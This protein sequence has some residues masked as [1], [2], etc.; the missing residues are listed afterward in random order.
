MSFLQQ[1]TPVVLTWN[2]APN[3]ARTLGRLAWAREVIVVDSGSE[4]A[5]AALVAAAPNARLIAHPF[6]G[7]AEQWRFALEESGIA[8]PWVL[9]LDADYL[10]DEALIAELAALSPPPEV[11]AY[12]VAFDY[13]IGG[14]RLRGS[15]Y[16]PNTVLFRRGAATPW[17]DGHTE[18]WAIAGGRVERLRGRILHDDRKPMAHWLAS[19]VRYLG[20]E[21]DKLQA[22]GARLDRRDRLR[23]RLWIAPWAVF[24]WCLFGKGLILQ[25]RAGLAY[26]Y[27]RLTAETM[28]ALYLLETGRNDPP[29]NPSLKDRHRP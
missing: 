20:R 28:L 15:L 27:Q 10:L 2:E 14:R 9:R 12:R 5:T 17:Q 6:A 1:I 21:R 8:T 26:A 13:A 29:D 19:Q 7:Q 11:A 3:I 25:G 18:R 4:D 16:P 23:R 22:P 24:L